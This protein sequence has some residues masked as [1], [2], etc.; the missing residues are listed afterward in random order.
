MTVDGQVAPKF[1]V[2]NGLRQGCVIAPTLSN[3]YFGLVIEQ[4][5][6]KCSEI[7]VDVH[8][9]CGGRLVGQRTRR[10]S[11]VRVTELLFADDAATVGTSRESMEY[12]AVELEKIVRVWG[13]ILSV[14]KTK[15]V[16]AGAPS[17]MED[18]RPLTQEGREIECVRDFKYL[19]SIVEEKGG[20]GSR[21][22]NCQG[23]QSFWNAYRANF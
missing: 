7:V 9:K 20:V 17:S 15:L 19:G 10:P 11:K 5:M 4:W 16:V 8:Y 12:A 14:G 13:L 22:K 2:C 3:L 18:L 1:E 23:I 21:G 6:T